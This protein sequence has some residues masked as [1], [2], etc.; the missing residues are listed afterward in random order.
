MGIH[1][2]WLDV[3]W[4]VRNNKQYILIDIPAARKCMLFLQNAKIDDEHQSENAI[5]IS[6]KILLMDLKICRYHKKN[7]VQTI[8]P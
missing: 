1:Q 5:G 4:D 6:L 2:T 3:N 7:M 8:V